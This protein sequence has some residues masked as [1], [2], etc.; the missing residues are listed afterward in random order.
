MI[1]TKHFWI[2][3]SLAIVAIILLIIFFP[4][5][6]NESSGKARVE[7]LPSEVFIL[8]NAQPEH[9]SVQL[10]DAFKYILE[11]LYDSEEVIEIDSNNLNKN[12]NFEP[13][14]IAF[15][16]DN[17]FEL[18]S[19]IRVYQKQYTLQ[20]IDGET[21]Y[22]YEFPTIVVRYQLKGLAGY[23][24][25]SV[26]P[27]PVYVSAR[28]SG[29]RDAII[30]NL[31]LGNELYMPLEDKIEDTSHNLPKLIC[32]ITGGFLLVLVITDFIVRIIPILREKEQQ[33][34]KLDK[35]SFIYQ[36]YHSLDTNINTGAD[37]HKILHQMDMLL[38]SVLSDNENL[39]WL[40]EPNF[41]LV[42]NVI[43]P[44]VIAIF[45]K[46]QEVYEA[47]NVNISSKNNLEEDWN[48]F[49]YIFNY[50]YSKEIE[51]WNN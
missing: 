4:H 19:N 43:R 39:D 29:D 8:V 31:K 12:V 45:N 33:E 22:L 50:Y 40:E 10:G 42:P 7:Q 32:F 9:N 15:T 3:T 17:D 5:S 13:F 44:S 16:N 6:N 35:D 21:E 51:A 34:K 41:E 1:K 30:N 14:E 28:L 11:V 20:L 27:N 47:Y 24:E 38:R 18:N 46:S 23:T 26:I 36:A 2:L 25:T 49:K 48:K 37:Y